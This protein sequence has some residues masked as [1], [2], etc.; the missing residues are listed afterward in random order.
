M[1]IRDRFVYT[2]QPV[3]N[4][5]VQSVWKPVVS[6]KWGMR[7]IHDFFMAFSKKFQNSKPSLKVVIDTNSYCYKTHW[8]S[9][10]FN[11]SCWLS[12][13][14]GVTTQFKLLHLVWFKLLTMKSI[15]HYLRRHCTQSEAHSC[16]STDLQLSWCF[17]LN[18]E[19]FFQ[20]H[21]RRNFRTSQGQNKLNAEFL[22]LFQVCSGDRLC[23]KIAKHVFEQGGCYGSW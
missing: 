23:K 9:F 7:H 15:F 17:Q 16:S 2:L 18:W 19:H 21:T 12:A 1:C 5:V 11:I 20:A 3:V 13:Q 6:C 22:G 4:T 10:T 8:D 14:Y